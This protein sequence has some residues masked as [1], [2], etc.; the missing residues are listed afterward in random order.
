MKHASQYTRI[1]SPL[2]EGGWGGFAF[3]HHNIARKCRLLPIK[4]R[5]PLHN[6]ELNLHF[7]KIMDKLLKKLK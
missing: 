1:R 6:F 7:Q 3:Q 5:Q 4:N 2:F